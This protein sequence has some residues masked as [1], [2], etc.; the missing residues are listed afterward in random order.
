MRSLEPQI[1]AV[2]KERATAVIAQNRKA[3]RLARRT[4]RAEQRKLR[5][6]ERYAAYVS[7][8]APV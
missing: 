7:G 3:V 8:D 2:M 6:E 1:L 5:R 4:E